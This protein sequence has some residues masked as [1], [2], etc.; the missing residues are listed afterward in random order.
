MKNLGRLLVGIAVL[1]GA[2]LLVKPRT[3]PVRPVA[4]PPVPPATPAPSKPKSILA[5]EE[6]LFFSNPV[7]VQARVFQV[8]D[9]YPNALAAT[10]NFSLNEGVTLNV[11]QVKVRIPSWDFETNLLNERGAPVTVTRYWY[12]YHP[13]RPDGKRAE[14]EVVGIRDGREILLYRGWLDGGAVSP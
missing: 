3:P 9:P 11:E 13:R 4:A 7:Q 1:F 8:P 14:M 2:L 10:A 12:E 6:P 5:P